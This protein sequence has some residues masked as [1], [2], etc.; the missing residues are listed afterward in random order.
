ME[1]HDSAGWTQTQTRRRELLA[2]LGAIEPIDEPE[3]DSDE[4]DDLD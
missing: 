2:K 1:R 3:E 4:E